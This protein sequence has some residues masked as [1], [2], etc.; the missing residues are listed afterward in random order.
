MNV[1]PHLDH[2]D[3]AAAIMSWRRTYPGRPDQAP[4]IRRFVRCLL[5]DLPSRDDVVN[6]TAEIVANAIYHTRSGQPGGCLTIEICR[7]PGRCLTLA[8]TDQG[9]PHVPRVPKAVDDDLLAENGRGLIILGT[10]AT[11]WGWTGDARGRTVIALFL[12]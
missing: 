11:S 4:K 3:N 8:I 1:L 2:I 10:T 5:A 9:G 7:W 12:D 6:A